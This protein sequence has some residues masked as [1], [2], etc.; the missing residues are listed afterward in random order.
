[1]KAKMLIGAILLITLPT[2][3]CNPPG[4]KDTSSQA[5]IE[6]AV[7]THT[8]AGATDAAEIPIDDET[9]INTPTPTIAP[10]ATPAPPTP[11]PNLTGLPMLDDAADVVSM[12]EYSLN[13]WTN[14]DALTVLDFYRE[15]LPDL[16]WELDYQDGQCLDD[17]RL[18]RRC[19]GWHGGED[20]PAESPIFFLRGEGEYLTLNA[21]EDGGGINIIIGIDPNVY[22]D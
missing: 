14:Q 12:D 17:R 11:M 5:D 21:L 18:T 9:I 3:V 8:P 22:G 13:Y 20:S 6:A 1:M 15:K 7:V 19:M 10:T 2:I 4:S 16:G